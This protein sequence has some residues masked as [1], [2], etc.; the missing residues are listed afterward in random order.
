[1]EVLSVLAN[2]PGCHH[3]GDVVLA[4]DTRSSYTFVEFHLGGM[5]A[6]VMVA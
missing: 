6:S 4:L 1:M 3:G 2:L 5:E